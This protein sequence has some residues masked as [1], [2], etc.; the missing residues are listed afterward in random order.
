MRRTRSKLI[1]LS[2]FA[3]LYRMRSTLCYYDPCAYSSQPLPKS[4]DEELPTHCYLASIPNTSIPPHE[5]NIMRTL[6][7]YLE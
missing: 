5:A 4:E 6:S 7:V 3:L 2:F 1:A